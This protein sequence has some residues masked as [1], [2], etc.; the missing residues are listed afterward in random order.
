MSQQKALMIMVVAIAWLWMP[1]ATGEEWRPADVQSG[2]L[3]LKMQAGIVAATRTNTEVTMTISGLVARVSVRQEFRNEGGEW[4][5]GIYVFPLPDEAAVDR[6]RLHIGERFIEGEIREKEKARKDYERARSEG[7]KASLVEQQRPNLF[8][9]S[10]ANIAPGERVVVEIEYFE[11]LHY[12][13]GTF[14]IRFPMTLT[15]RYIPGA[16]LPD[17]KGSGWSPDTI[18]V[19]DASFIT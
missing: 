14:A 13:N 15:P 10:V 12:D 9:T 1:V 16:P 4:V 19:S 6:M 5:E 8:T 7:R 17:R 11:D 18:R 3:L 2:T